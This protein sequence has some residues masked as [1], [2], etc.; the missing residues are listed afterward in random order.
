MMVASIKQDI[1]YTLVTIFFL[2]FYFY[3]FI[4][5]DYPPETL[6]FT[7]IQTDSVVF[8][9]FIFLMNSVLLF[10]YFIIMLSS[11]KIVRLISFV[12]LFVMAIVLY[13][14][15]SLNNKGFN[16]EEA[17]IIV[18]SLWVG[19]SAIKFY[20]YKVYPTIIVV[21][22]VFI[23]LYFIINFKIKVIFSVN[24][25]VLSLILFLTYTYLNYHIFLHTR[26]HLRVPSISDI[27]I[28]LL[29]AYKKFKYQ[30]LRDSILSTPLRDSNYKNII[31]IVG[32]S[33]RGDMLSINGY[34][35]N[36]TPYLRTLTDKDGFY[37]YGIASSPANNSAKSNIIYQ[38]GVQINSFPDLD[39][40][41]DVMIN[42]NLFQFAKKSGFKTTYM[43]NQYSILLNNMKLSDLNHIDNYVKIPLLSPAKN[44]RDIYSINEIKKI[45][46]N[47]KKNF[48]YLL[49]QGAHVNYEDCYPSSY[50]K[51]QP[52][53]YKNKDQVINSYL[54]AISYSV[55]IFFKNLISSGVNLDTTIIIYIS[56]HGEVPESV[57]LKS[58]Y[59][60]HGTFINPPIE[61]AT[62]PFFI[63]TKNKNFI[64][65]KSNVNRV[66]GF[67]MFPTILSLFGYDFYN[68]KTIF[69]N[70]NGDRQ[71]ISGDIFDSSRTYI[72]DFKYKD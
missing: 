62:V 48:I 15:F 61:E 35:K 70:L 16:L 72:N 67:N 68:G 40:K 30:G 24:K 65:N 41:Q 54:N 32:E 8:S 18:E 4:F 20:F 50:S 39:N 27:P 28:K 19:Q 13:S 26:D 60:T 2:F 43:D 25:V 49:K 21:T 7:K 69:K 57:F 59:Y 1:F 3:F 46:R 71:F 9:L 56:D 53:G 31:F 45:I 42:P 37:N 51:F 47:N 55:D 11:S 36:T 10:T 22:L 23:I 66:S 52:V 12:M 6:Y 63:F 38:S 33:V 5:F 44:K 64:F 58:M 34:D 29:Y 17:N 14:F